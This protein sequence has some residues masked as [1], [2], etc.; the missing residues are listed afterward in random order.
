MELNSA[1]MMKVTTQESLTLIEQTFAAHFPAES[2]DFIDR[3]FERVDDL[4]EGRYSGYQSSDTT[5]H[6]FTHTCEATVAVVRILDGH[7]RGE[8][9]P[10]LCHRDFE[11]MVVASF[12]HD[13]GFIKEI[14]DDEGTGAKYTV[15]HV[16]RSGQFTA[17]FLE[18][19][20]VTAD[21]IH[22]IQLAIECTGIQVDVN[23][24]AFGNELGRFM[25]SVVGTGDILAQMAAPDYPEKL[26]G[27][28]REFAEASTYPGAQGSGIDTYT[29]ANDLM[30]K[31]RGFYDGYVLH[32]L[33]TQWGGVYHSLERH[34]EEGK[35]EYFQSID[36]NLERI[37][38]MLLS[39]EAP[40][41][42]V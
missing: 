42:P 38:R 23:S 24:L 34:F 28:Y 31:T 16:Q 39:T 9:P 5:Y 20:D 15:T 26:D 37:D 1:S 36:A 35:N 4:F 18:E 7:I 32:M 3:V 12:L 14:G 2:T 13:S 21:E 30:R 41:E 29:S 33:E 8:E 19:F 10:A 25:G 27:L 40:T 17:N 11:L 6:D 22:L